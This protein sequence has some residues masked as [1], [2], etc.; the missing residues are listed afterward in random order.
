ME[1]VAVSRV[2]MTTD[3]GK[4]IR[5]VRSIIVYNGVL[6]AG[7]AYLISFTFLGLTLILSRGVCTWKDSSREKGSS[8]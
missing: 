8:A 3:M 7:V 5:L 6:E 4:R 1:E 2:T